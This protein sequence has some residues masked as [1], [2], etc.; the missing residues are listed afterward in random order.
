MTPR[1]GLLCLPLLLVSS[2]AT[3]DLQQSETT[4]ATNNTSNDLVQ[5]SAQWWGLSPDEFV[6]KLGLKPGQYQRA[7]HPVDTNKTVI[8]TQ[9]VNWQPPEIHPLSFDFIEGNGLVE[10]SGFH[11]QGDTEDSVVAAMVKKYGPYEGSGQLLS[12]VAY[13]WKVGGTSL[14]VNRNGSFLRPAK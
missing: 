13:E 9:G 12:F 2:C 3:N 10:I 4:V 7:P 5:L 1:L 6:T 8:I 14:T 11:R